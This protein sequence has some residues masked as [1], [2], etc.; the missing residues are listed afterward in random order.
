[1]LR[2]LTI[3]TAL[4]IAAGLTS[5]AGVQAKPTAIAACGT[6]NAPG[7]YFLSGDI[8]ATGLC[9][10]ITAGA[11]RAKLNLNGFTITGN[12]TGLGISVAANNVQI[13]GPG[14]I[15]G[16]D[17]AIL[18]GAVSNVKVR[19]VVVVDNDLHGIDL[20]GTTDS[21]IERCVVVQ[22][23]SDGIR[24]LGASNNM[25]ERNEVMVNTQ[26]GIL[27][28]NAALNNI[29]QANNVSGNG[30]GNILL[31]G[32]AINNLVQ[33]NIAFAV[34][35]SVDI[36]NSNS[37]PNIFSNNLCEFGFPVTVCYKSGGVPLPDFN[38][39]HF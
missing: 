14:A 6:I 1:M 25:I 30:A 29:I 5:V 27:L 38:I 26:R 24:L 12:G 34:G 35:S 21:V 2:T 18:I 4:V 3:L 36:N 22:N 23:G 11:G 13:L 16:F 10:D 37:A 31:A 15:E 8:V 9:I 33:D 32:G 19:E 17:T 20:D 39:D 28:A 7:Q